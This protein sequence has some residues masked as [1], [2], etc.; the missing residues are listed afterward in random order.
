MRMCGAGISGFVAATNLAEPGFSVQVL[1][2]RGR[3]GGSS[4]WHP[5][6]HQQTLDLVS[7]SDDNWHFSTGCVPLEK[8]PVK[9]G[10]VLAGTMS[11]MI[12]PFHLNGM[13]PALISGKIAPRWL[14]DT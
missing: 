3:V 2:K 13:S 6:A 9:D 10:L 7:T 12:D 4:E 8:N 5:S 1:E 14:H 11:G